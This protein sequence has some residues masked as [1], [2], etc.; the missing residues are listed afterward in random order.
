M[1]LL[2]LE[3][4]G[5]RSQEYGCVGNIVY[6]GKEKDHY[7]KKITILTEL[8][9]EILHIQTSIWTVSEEVLL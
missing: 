5:T 1:V 4:V 9:S 8:L 3:N 7:G 2:F 6:K